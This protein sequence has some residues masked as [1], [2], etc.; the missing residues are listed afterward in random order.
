MAPDFRLVGGGIIFWNIR[1]AT[2]HKVFS[3]GSRDHEVVIIQALQKRLY[4]WWV[5]IARKL[6]LSRCR[7]VGGAWKPVCVPGPR[8][9]PP[10]H[11]PS[12]HGPAGLFLWLKSPSPARRLPPTPRPQPVSPLSVQWLQPSRSEGLGWSWELTDPDGPEPF[13]NSPGLAAPL[14]LV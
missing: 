7:G 6:T 12:V 11:L 14:V 4:F 5:S 3:S 1:A 10:A 2:A 13:A 9:H 8:P